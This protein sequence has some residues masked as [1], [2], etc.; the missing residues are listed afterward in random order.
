MFLLTLP[1]WEI[2]PCAGVGGYRAFEGTDRTHLQSL[3]IKTRAERLSATQPPAILQGH[4]AD[5][6]R[7]GDGIFFRNARI[8]LQ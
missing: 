7:A 8:H 3:I 1:F 5:K 2:T 4:N 6:R